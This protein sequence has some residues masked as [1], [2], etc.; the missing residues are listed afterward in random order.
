MTGRSKAIKRKL[1]PIFSSASAVTAINFQPVLSHY[2]SLNGD[3]PSTILTN[4]TGVVFSPR[5]MLQNPD[6]H[7]SLASVY[8]DQYQNKDKHTVY[9]VPS[10]HLVEILE[11]TKSLSTLKKLQLHYNKISD[12]NRKDVHGYDT[13]CLVIHEGV[14][15]PATVYHGHLAGQNRNLT[16]EHKDVVSN[17]PISASVASIN[18]LEQQGT[19][20]TLPLAKKEELL[21]DAHKRNLTALLSQCEK[22]IQDLGHDK[23]SSAGM[24][25]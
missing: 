22:A 18:S 6:L 7:Q 21:N 10:Y 8:T 17:Q 11:D 16:Y 13:D 15:V 19:T 1:A 3:Q 24:G 2:V 20:T 9:S 23:A 25:R 5:A 4:F 12:V 14:G